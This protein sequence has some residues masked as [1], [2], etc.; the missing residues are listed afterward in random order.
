MTNNEMR[1]KKAADI[2][3]KALAKLHR[4]DPEMAKRLGAAM[5]EEAEAIRKGR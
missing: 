3:G 1:I 2:L 4:E 5:A